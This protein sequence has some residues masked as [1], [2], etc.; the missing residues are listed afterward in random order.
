MDKYENK[1]IQQIV[2]FDFPDFSKEGSEAQENFRKFLAGISEIETLKKYANE[3]LH[4]EDKKF[5]K[6]K[7]GFVLQDIVN[8]LAKRLDLKVVH[9]RYSGASKKEDTG[10]DGVWETDDHGFVVEVKASIP[11]GADLKAVS[12]YR[13]KLLQEQKIKNSNSL[14]LVIGNMGNN[15]KVD[16]EAQIRGLPRAWDTR[17]ITVGSLI[18]LVELKV[19]ESS[20]LNPDYFYKILKPFDYIRVDALVTLLNDIVSDV[21]ETEEDGIPET[22]E[23]T[24]SLQEINDNHR[25]RVLKTIET[26]HEGNLVQKGR[27]SFENSKT[28]GL[29]FISFS[30]NYGNENLASYWYSYDYKSSNKCD[31]LALYTKEPKDWFYLIPMRAIE[32]LINED[33]MPFNDYKKFCRIHFYIE[34]NNGQSKMKFKKGRGEEDIEQYKVSLVS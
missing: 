17:I 22:E 9:G 30:K 8:T 2:A 32:D 15:N 29:F 28:G 3:C 31:F 12:G 23:K 25:K 19:G 16:L 14:L 26:M 21:V 4:N 24:K 1:T 11:Y 7:N 10:Y 34:I 18:Q 5:D 33:K 20:G 27:A 6:T 13:D